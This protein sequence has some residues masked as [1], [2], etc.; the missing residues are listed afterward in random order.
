MIIHFMGGD[1]IDG[2]AMIP[3]GHGSWC[4]HPKEVWANRF[5]EQ[6]AIF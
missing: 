3:G 6:G 4:G 5:I 2:V 1:S